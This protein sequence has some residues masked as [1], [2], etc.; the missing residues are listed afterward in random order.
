[1]NGFAMDFSKYDKVAKK[2]DWILDNPELAKEIGLRASDSIMENASID[3]SVRGFMQIVMK[4][5][6]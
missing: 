3:T 2:I 1:M 4:T 5:F 6:S